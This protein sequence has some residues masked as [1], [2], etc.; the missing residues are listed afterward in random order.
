METLANGKCTAES[1]LKHLSQKIEQYIELFEQEKRSIETQA[2]IVQEAISLAEEECDRVEV[3]A[4]MEDLQ[5]KIQMLEA[6]IHEKES[7]YFFYI[8]MKMWKS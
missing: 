7:E 5:K 2:S 4:T 1:H 3:T 8:Y 6:R